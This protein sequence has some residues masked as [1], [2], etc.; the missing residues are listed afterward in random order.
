MPGVFTRQAYEGYVAPA[1]E[2]AARR[3]EIAND[4]VL[5]DGQPQQQTE[6]RSA[7]A[8]QAALTEQYFADYAEH[9]QGFMN[10]LQWE[11]AP[12]LHRLRSRSSG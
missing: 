6:S 11:P 2:Q 9:W 5:T 7:E 8:L 3:T 12:T 4:W 10:S 1:I